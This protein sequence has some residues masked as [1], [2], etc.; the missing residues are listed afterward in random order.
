MGIIMAKKYGAET[1]DRP[2]CDI[3]GQSVIWAGATEAENRG[4]VNLQL[5][6]FVAWQSMVFLNRP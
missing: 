1:A 2:S 6:S 5:I 3:G 4:S